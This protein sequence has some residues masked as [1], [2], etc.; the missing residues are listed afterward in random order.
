M[1][2]WRKGVVCS[3]W[4]DSFEAGRGRGGGGEGGG[5]ELLEVWECFREVVERIR[6]NVSKDPQQ[7]KELLD[8]S[9]S[10]WEKEDLSVLDRLIPLLVDVRELTRKL[11]GCESPEDMSK[12]LRVFVPQ[13]KAMKVGE[14]KVIPGGWWTLTS[15]GYV[16]A[17]LEKTSDVEFTFTLCNRGEGLQYHP[18]CVFS[19][20]EPSQC[21]SEFCF[22]FFHAIESLT[23]P[24]LGIFLFP[25]HR[26]SSIALVSRCL[27]F[28]LT[29]W[30]MADSG[31]FGFVY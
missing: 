8:S 14:E 17:L 29:R 3:H 10:L 25:K 27:E 13:I 21:A 26:K 2:W 22:K 6:T 15:T 4:G 19:S 11:G 9:L 20:K 23:H 30:K 24:S 7:H 18:S 1:A 16:C 28:L 5:G 12:F 31:W